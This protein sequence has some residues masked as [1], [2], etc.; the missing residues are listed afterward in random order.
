MKKIVK[1]FEEA[2]KVITTINQLT[3]LRNFQDLKKNKLKFVC[4]WLYDIFL[5]SMYTYTKYKWELLPLKA[6][7]Q[8]SER[9]MYSFLIYVLS[10]AFLSL[11]FVG[12]FQSK[13]TMLLVKEFDKVDE[14]LRKLG[15]K[16]EY[17]SLYAHVV[18]VGLFWLVNTLLLCIVYIK[19]TISI[20][21]GM[22][23]MASIFSYIYGTNVASIVLYDFKI[24]VYW[25]GSRFKQTNELLRTFF[26]EGHQIETDDS[27]LDASYNSSKR[28]SLNRWL[29]EHSFHGSHVHP[30]HH[31]L[32]I[33]YESQSIKKVH[34]LQQIRFM[35][36]ELCGVSKKLNRIFDIQLMVYVSMMLIYITVLLYYLYTVFSDSQELLDKISVVIVY[37]VEVI[38]YCA[39]IIIVS[40]SCEYTTSQANRAIEIIHACSV[41]EID[42]EL[43]DEILQFSLQMSHTQ[44]G[45]SKSVFFRLNYTFIRNCVSFVATYLVILIQ[46]NQTFITPIGNSR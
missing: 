24:Y 38:S 10:I 37:T 12:L 45:K 23:T 9:L 26:V 25:L 22:Y 31:S 14:N 40:Y 42:T 18:G 3:S 34:L 39:K 7:P 8:N 13:N 27:I 33:K 6:W 17:R 29:S 11:I 16:I 19:W 35:H 5:V 1:N 30:S 15:C 32:N 4:Y 36:L 43:K 21:S 46:W 28:F 2:T 44:L 41:Y 20:K